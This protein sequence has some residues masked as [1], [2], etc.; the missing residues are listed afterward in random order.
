MKSIYIFDMDGTLTDSML[1]VARNVFRVLD[2]ERIP[3]TVEMMKKL[4]PAG[5]YKTAEYFSALGVPGTVEEILARLKSGLVET[6]EKEVPLKEG[7]RE[8]LLRT[9]T[10]GA[11]FFI[12][13]G[14]PSEVAEACMRGKGLDA[15]FEGYYSTDDLHLAKNDPA[16]YTRRCEIIGCKPEDVIYYD[17]NVEALRTAGS[18]GFETYAVYDGQPTEVLAAMKKDADHYITSF[19]ELL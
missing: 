4:T 2:E 14:S 3:Y 11:R 10:E 19:S 8:Y 5:Y 7:V 9:H 16:I 12:L 1:Y 18:V 6:Y 15:L 17:D 13:T